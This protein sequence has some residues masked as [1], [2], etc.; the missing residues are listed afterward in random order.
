MLDVRTGNGDEKARVKLL[1]SEG[2]CAQYAAL[3]YCWGHT[4]QLTTIQTR[5]PSFIKDGIE[6]S[7]LPKTLQD[8]ITVTRKLGIPYLWIDSLCIIQDSDDD[9][10][11]EITKMP[12]IYKGAITTISAAIARDCD[13]GFLQHREEVQAILNTSF[14]LEYLLDD[15]NAPGVESIQGVSKEDTDG[16]FV[17]ADSDCGYKIRDFDE[18]PINQRAWTLQESWLAPRLLIYGS[19]PL[20][21]QCLSKSASFGGIPPSRPAPKMSSLLTIGDGIDLG[22]EDSFLPVKTRRKFFDK[23]NPTVSRS[24]LAD[25]WRDIVRQYTRRTMTDP[26]DKLPALSGIAAEFGRLSGDEYL[27]GLWK[28]SL[29]YGLLWHQL[30]KSLA[31]TKEV[32]GYRAPSWSWASVDGA[33]SIRSPK[34]WIG[35]TEVVIESVETTPLTL[36]APLGKVVTGKLTL[37]GPVRRMPWEKVQE[38]YVILDLDQSAHLVCIPEKQL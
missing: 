37:T 33:I 23:S 38:R 24:R 8:A 19:G 34:T 36:L 29:P 7:K 6:I 13:E 17:C 15:E 28:S 22:R 35:T 27:A 16:I 1:A 9:K 31:G 30:S 32:G 25:E 26:G 14:A 5:L 3:S 18:E 10:A 21:W 4:P 20:Q 11:R 12:Q 2:L